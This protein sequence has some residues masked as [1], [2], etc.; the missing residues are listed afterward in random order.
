MFLFFLGHISNRGPKRLA[1]SAF[2]TC[3]AF[4]V[5]ANIS[6]DQ[7]PLGTKEAADP[8]DAYKVE[9]AK[10]KTSFTNRMFKRIREPWPFAFSL[11]F[12][13]VLAVFV[14]LCGL[15]MRL[16]FS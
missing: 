13:N 6:S 1:T 14:Q 7:F 3:K 9:A 11:F 10:I 4:P 8:A 12:L 2:Q 5:L 15:D 16:T